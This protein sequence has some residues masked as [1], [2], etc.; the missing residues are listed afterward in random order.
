M[1]TVISCFHQF[2]QTV[3]QNLC[4]LVAYN[5]EDFVKVADG[6]GCYFYMQMFVICTLVVSLVL[7]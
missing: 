7:G 5:L 2:S 6:G 1:K 3:S 4:Q